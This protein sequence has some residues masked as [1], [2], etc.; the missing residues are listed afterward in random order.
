MGR[1]QSK[2]R[3]YFHH[4]ESWRGARVSFLSFFLLHKCRNFFF[5]FFFFVSL[6]VR[7][8][9]WDQ[10]FG[11]THSASWEI[12]MAI[13][14]SVSPCCWP[15]EV[16]GDIHPGG[17]G[18]ALP[19]SISVLIAK[20]HQANPKTSSF[21]EN[22]PADF[23]GLWIHS[24]QTLDMLEQP[25]QLL[26]TAAAAGTHKTQYRHTPNAFQLRLHPKILTLVGAG[27]V[28]SDTQMHGNTHTW[29]SWCI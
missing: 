14:P 28:P 29:M 24:G 7:V 16:W 18:V 2:I 8:N 23:K 9:P 10:N 6:V 21:H 4:R 26:H 19:F 3:G 22:T 17:S 11:K 13:I 12:S 27:V 1:S 20:P 25:K 5:F 15:F